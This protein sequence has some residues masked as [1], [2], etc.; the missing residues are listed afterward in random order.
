MKFS[1]TRLAVG[2]ALAAYV[3]PRLAK[4][5]K[6]DVVPY[7]K[8]LTAKT[9]KAEIKGIVVK[10]CKDAEPML[11]P[12][13]NGAAGKMGPDDVIHMLASHIIGGEAP[14]AE[15]QESD[16]MPMEAEGEGEIPALDEAQRKF[17]TDCGMDE[18]QIEAFGK[19]MGKKAGD[20][21]VPADPT[22]A[23]PGDEK[24]DKGVTKEAMDAAIKKAAEDTEK[25]VRA[26]ATA[27]A[28]AREFVRPWVGA[29][30]MAHDSV[31]KV[32]RSTLDALG[33]DAKAVKDV[34]ALRILIERL[35][36]PGDRTVR[37]SD[38]KT[39]EA[40]V[41]DELAKKYPHAAAI[42]LN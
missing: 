35:P 5:K 8:D 42:G 18:G 11:A 38:S 27:L 10:L 29:M 12:D 32:L 30:S 40:S 33:Q 14:S 4:D 22:E 15:A 16:E 21:N 17:L 31:E 26:E 39:V 24:D 3:G 34:A 37:A 23:P 36:K 2:M 13:P 41:S 19:M 28:E 9:Y 1:K 6:L 25:R 7:V 20:M